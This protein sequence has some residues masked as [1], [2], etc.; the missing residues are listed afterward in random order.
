MNLSIERLAISTGIGT[1]L[2]LILWPALATLLGVLGVATSI[3]VGAGTVFPVYARL[4]RSLDGASRRRRV[5]TALVVL[6][7]IVTI[8]QT[9]RL[10]AHMEDIT[11]EWWVSTT[12]P[13]WS[14]HACMTAYVYAADLDRQG[15]PNVYDAGH[16]P[17]LTPSAEPHPT[18]ENLTVEDPYQYPPPFLLLPRLAIALSNDYL[19]IRAVWYSIN[20]LLF[21]G[22]A[23][24]LARWV[25]GR[26]GAFAAALVPLA[27]ISTP[28]LLNFQYGQ[29]H[30]ATVALAVA[31]FLAFE[32][33]R[34]RLGGALL[35]TAI[36]AKGFPGI[37]LIPMLLQRRFREVAW[38]GAWTVGLTALA[39]GVLGSEPFRAFVEY[40]IG[41]VGSGAAFAFDEAWPDFK[42]LLLAGNV[43]PFSMVR[44]LGELGVAGATDV[45][46][47]IVHGI[48]ALGI[49]GVALIASRVRAR[50]ARAVVWLALLNLAAMTS[51]AAWGDYVPV[52]T[53]WLLTLLVGGPEALRVPVL[54][55][56]GAFAFFVPGIVPIGSFLGP[57]VS[58]VLSIVGTLLLIGIN[59]WVTLRAARLPVAVRHAQRLAIEPA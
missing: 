20:V 18:V 50:H 3:L 28:S 36:L 59:G 35:A 23:L 22:T 54:A 6:V 8:V 32:R 34:P 48:F 21:L 40:Q 33:R 26:A 45:T 49:L 44:K 56:V 29:F 41:H 13:L 11:S 39:W 43:S 19:S 31:A 15:E 46:A 5:R 1:C 47:R 55:G 9:A 7:G 37:L 38:T 58:M 57:V 25:G 12:H 17:G 4:P 10:G 27:W 24:L 14:K 16:Y 30:V 2:G 42:A 53:L 51:P 52:G